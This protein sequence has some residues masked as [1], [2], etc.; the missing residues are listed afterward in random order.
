[1]SVDV[2]FLNDH[3]K[4]EMYCRVSRFVTVCVETRTGY[5]YSIESDELAFNKYYILKRDKAT[6][7]STE[8][9]T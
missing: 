4:V 2:F 6:K 8:L 1:M 3:I 7:L 5:E 9:F